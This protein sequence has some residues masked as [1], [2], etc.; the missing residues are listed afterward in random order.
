MGRARIRVEPVTIDNKID[1][2]LTKDLSVLSKK[3]LKTLKFVCFSLAA[4]IILN[5]Y[6]FLR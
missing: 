4:S 3:R 1:R 5:I 6:L 2:Y